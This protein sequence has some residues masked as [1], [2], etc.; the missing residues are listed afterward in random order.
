MSDV[1]FMSNVK[2]EGKTDVSLWGE[3]TSLVWCGLRVVPVVG[4]SVTAPAKIWW[5]LGIVRLRNCV[6]YGRN[7]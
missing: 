7:V 1:D 3:V 5:L 2:N 6:E 4:W